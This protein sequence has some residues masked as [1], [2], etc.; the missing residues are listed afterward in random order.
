VVNAGLLYILANHWMAMIYFMIQ[1]HEQLTFIISDGHASFDPITGE[2]NICESG[3]TFCYARSIYFVLG[4]VTSIAFRDMMPF[5]NVEILWELCVALIGAVVVAIFCGAVEA[6]LNDVDAHSD[7][8][9]KVKMKHVKG[10]IAFR[11]LEGD[12]GNAM[13]SHYELV[14][15][16]QKSLGDATS[17]M[18]SALPLSLSMDIHLNIR[19]HILELVPLFREGTYASRRR[20]AVVLQPQVEAWAIFAFYFYI[21][22]EKHFTIAFLIHCFLWCICFSTCCLILQH[23]RIWCADGTT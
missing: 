5:T 8:A 2:H 3:I 15:R 11:N 4:T 22:F 1:R 23:T 12:I 16:E 10:F 21:L 14:W 6:Y 17:N 20:I 19:S 7:A 13:L 18:M 9:F